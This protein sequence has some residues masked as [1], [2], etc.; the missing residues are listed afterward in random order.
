VQGATQNFPLINRMDFKTSDWDWVGAKGQKFSV[1]N[2]R[3]C[4][5]LPSFSF[6]L[7]CMCFKIIHILNYDYLTWKYKMKITDFPGRYL[8]ITYDSPWI[9]K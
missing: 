5:D 8:H 3:A 2:T 6:N 4:K 9:L 1:Q 7:L